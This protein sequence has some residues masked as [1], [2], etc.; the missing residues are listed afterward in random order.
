MCPQTMNRPLPGNRED[1]AVGIFFLLIFVFSLP[2]WGLSMLTGLPLF[3]LNSFA[4]IMAAL[5]LTYREHGM[6][7]TKE[8]LKKVFDYYRIERKLWYVP[9]F[10][11]LPAIYILAQSL[12]Y[13]SGDALPEFQITIY[14][15]PVFVVGFFV[16]AAGEEVGWSGYA[17]DAM[18]YRRGALCAALLIGAVWAA[19]HIVPDLIAG[20]TTDWILWQRLYSIALRILIVWIFNNTG[21]SVFAVIV[22]HAMDNVSFVMFPDYNSY[23]DPFYVFIPAAL[24]ALLVIFVW[25]PRTLAHYRFRHRG[26][27]DAGAA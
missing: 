5:I 19:W 12:M 17:L 14:L 24:T 7:R 21:G 4:P 2:L 15:A 27:D 11:L 3:I 25:G 9:I 20:H 16:L 1:K 23:Y 6:R 22:F 18:Q 10:G 26:P 13:F 8:L